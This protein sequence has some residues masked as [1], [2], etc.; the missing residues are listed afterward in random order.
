MT[1]ER[2]IRGRP[3]KS[4]ALQQ[5]LSDNLQKKN[6][7]EGNGEQEDRDKGIHNIKVHKDAHRRGGLYTRIILSNVRSVH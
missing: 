5:S 6:M 3:E 4:F 2:A 7:C 1:R